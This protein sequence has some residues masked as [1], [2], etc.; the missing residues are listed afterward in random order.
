MG[1]AVNQRDCGSGVDFQW[2]IFLVV[3]EHAK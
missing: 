2:A 3:V 1:D